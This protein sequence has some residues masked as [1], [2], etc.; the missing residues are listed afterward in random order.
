MV[1]AAGAACAQDYPSRPIRIITTAAGGGGDITSRIVAQGIAGPL[2]QQV[3][4]DNRVTGIVATE[5][6]SK[7]VPDGYTLT[8]GGRIWI[9]PILI[10]VPYDAEKDFLP[11]TQIERSV[12]VIA[13]H[14]SV[15]ANSVKEL[16][17]LTKA[18]PGELNFGAI[19][20]SGSFHFS[21]EMLISAAGM[22]MTRIPYKGAAPVLA[23]LVKGEV[24]MSVLDAS[25]IMPLAKA[26]KLKALA[27]SSTD[28]TPLVPGLPG[29]GVPGYEYI[30]CTGLWAPAKTPGAI[31]TRLN[32]EVV[33]YIS[34]PEVKERFLNTG[35][36]VVGS[37]P[38]EFQA[39]IKADAAI[40]RKSIKD[41]GL[42]TN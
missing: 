12:H 27:V 35:V 29:P 1:F 28:P 33:R 19:S 24:Q 2:G 5:A 23:A 20:V 8:V 32:Q 11:I 37:S 30:N 4:V 26:G 13:V 9:P 15:P 18:K 3:I 17:A 34:R 21:A 6:A 38:A 41:S 25:Q 42:T 36:E 16:I 22:Q 14:P 7:A 39:F 40:Q 10:D 31:I